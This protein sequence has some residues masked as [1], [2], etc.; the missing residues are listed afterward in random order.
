MATITGSGGDDTLYGTAAADTIYGNGGNDTL[1]GGGGA[2]R[3]DG[4]IGVDTVLYND[5]TVGVGVNLVTGHGSGGTAE[6]DTY[7][8]IENV[9]GSFYDDSITGDDGANL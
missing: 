3:L 4:G 9:K 2:D 5:S 1:R 6:G 8:S 7:V